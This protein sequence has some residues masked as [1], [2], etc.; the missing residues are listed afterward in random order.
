MI[1]TCGNTFQLAYSWWLSAVA[2]SAAAS[3]C[4]GGIPLS[5][6]YTLLGPAGWCQDA[7]RKGPAMALWLTT[8]VHN[9]CRAALTQKA[10]G[11]SAKLL[12]RTDQCRA[13]LLSANL[14]W[15]AADRTEPPAAPQSLPQ[16][17]F[18]DHHLQ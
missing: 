5:H 10:T 6:T 7:P 2:S 17:C 3:C 13:L 8:P 15:Q 18:A 4:K 14:H 16:V 1:C 12:L 9:A 11:V